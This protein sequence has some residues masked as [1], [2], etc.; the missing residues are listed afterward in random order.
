ML[1]TAC[2]VLALAFAAGPAAAQTDVAERDLRCMIVMGVFGSRA[3]S[4]QDK[5]AAAAGFTYFLG[6]LQGRDPALDVKARIVAAAQGLGGVAGLQPDVA[7]CGD[8]LKALG[9][10][11]Q[12]IGQALQAVGQRPGP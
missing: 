8:E 7:R 10:R 9:A 11:S 2:A 5:Q 3:Q 12:E 6:R 4:D 1:R